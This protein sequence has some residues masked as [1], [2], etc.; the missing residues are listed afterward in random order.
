MG[1]P[2]LSSLSRIFS[3]HCY[4]VAHPTYEVG[5]NPSYNVVSWLVS[6]F[7]IVSNFFF[8]IIQAPSN[9][10]KVHYC[11]KKSWQT[12]FFVQTN[13]CKKKLNI[14]CLETSLACL[15]VQKNQTAY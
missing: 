9:V 7:A 4:L 13:V 2:D 1:H 3:W 12:I 5:Y 8:Q 14:V 15:P 11:G 10:W 6:R